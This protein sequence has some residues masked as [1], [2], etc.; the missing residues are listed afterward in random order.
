MILLRKRLFPVLLALM[1]CVGLLGGVWT[2]AQAATVNYV[3]SGKYIYNWGTRDEVATFL[4]PMAEEWYE[5][6]NTTYAELSALSGS[7]STSGVTSSTLYNAL[8]ELMY[9]NLDSPTSYDATRELFQYT[10]VQ[11][12]GKDTKKISSFYSGDLIGPS[13][14]SGKTWNREHVW[15]NSKSNSGSGSD[16]KRETD[17][18][19][20][21]PTATS[22]NG[23]RGNKA[24]GESSNFYHPNSE[25]DN[26]H[27]LRGDVSRIVLYV[28]V[29]WGGSSQHDGARDYMWGSSG[30]MESLSVLLKW[31]EEDPVD[32]W[33]L[34]RN[35]AV[36]AITGTRNVFVDYP[37]LVFD[38]FDTAVPADYTTPSGGD[39]GGT[40][41]NP[42]PDP[43]P[44]PE[45]DPDTPTGSGSAT[46]T[47]DDKAKRTSFDTSKQVW[48]ENGITV[49][50]NKGSSTSNVADYANPARFYKS[51][52]ITIA[53]PGMTSLVI[54][55]SNIGDSYQWTTTLNNADVSYTVTSNVYTITFSTAVDSIT[56][57]AANQVRANS[58]T[59]TY[60]GQE[61]PTACDHQYDNA[62]DTACNLCGETRTVTH[63]Y[64][65]VLTVAPTC[66]AAGLRTYTCAVCGN[67]YTETVAALGEHTYTAAC[68]T[69]C[70]ICGTERTIVAQRTA[71]ITFDSAD[72]RTTYNTSKQVWEENGI[73]VTNNKGSSTS[74]VAD[75]AKPARFYKSSQLIL[76]YPG[77]TAIVFD[78]NSSSYATALKNSISGYTVTVSSDKV[79][80]TLSAATDT[81]TIASLSGGQ[82][83][84]DGITV[85]AAGSGAEHTYDDAF[86]PDCNACGTVREGTALYAD[87]VGHSTMATGADSY[88]L[89]FKFDL[90]AAGAAMDG[91]YVADMTAAT[92]TY[93]GVTCQVVEMGAVM[94]NDPAVGTDPAAMRRENTTTDKTVIDI[95]AVYLWDCGADS[96]SFAV[97]ITNIPSKHQ[98]TTIYARP[99]C[100]IAYNGQQYTVYD[101]TVCASYADYAV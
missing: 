6:N 41:P 67:S 49:T 15:P 48:E 7:S 30:V 17:I 93:M 29:C 16:T 27:D 94:S 73:T 35:D 68:D 39:H 24:Y 21:R 78:C 10:D 38:L 99:Y 74:N 86:D 82:V 91:R 32:T 11:N 43:D 98:S 42:D 19:M 23:S 8:Y 51:S 61:P 37:E 53:Y 1:L 36:Q 81:F 101:D 5:K 34:G 62:C 79:T 85:T 71:T 25:S 66:G 22:E 9:G 89:A 33:E 69:V 97:R 52:T 60:A 31:V 14:D 2:P 77:M 63:A 88:G 4:S 44:D 95:P 96:C 83:R 75:Y 40:T 12:S 92:V 47:F 76:A 54:D 57:T 80:V 87:A 18:M 55:A 50:N 65:G 90:L 100:V 26:A 70:N 3:T 45:P 28:Y 58:I 20:L 59:V 46:I 84:M 64:E 13:W 72:K 56:L